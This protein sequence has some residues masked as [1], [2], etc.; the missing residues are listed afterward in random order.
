MRSELRA[1]FENQVSEL[2]QRMPRLKGSARRDATERL[3]S[4]TEFLELVDLIGGAGSTGHG[5]TR[6]RPNV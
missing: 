6:A 5:D 3:E 2:K 4:L 1:T